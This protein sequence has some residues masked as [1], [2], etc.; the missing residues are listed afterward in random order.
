MANIWG[1]RGKRLCP[2]CNT[3]WEELSNI[4]KTWPLWTVEQTRRVITAANKLGRSD[5]KKVL[6]EHGI[7]DVEVSLS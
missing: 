5:H 2:I 7:H 4:S 1:G 6:S 3:P